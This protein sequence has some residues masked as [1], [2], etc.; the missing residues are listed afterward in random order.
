M[1]WLL[2]ALT[3]TVSSLAFRHMN[4]IHVYI[5]TGFE[6]RSGVYYTQFNSVYC[7]F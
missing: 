5:I 2:K 3:G 7:L 4:Y 1:V 6:Q